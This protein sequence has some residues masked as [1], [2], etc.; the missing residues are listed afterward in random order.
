M[1][2]INGQC[3]ESQVARLLEKTPEQQMMNRVVEGTGISPWE[4]R[5]LVDEVRKVYLPGKQFQLR[6]GQLMYT[7][8]SASEG[9]GKPLKECR[10][11]TVVLT[12]MSTE[13]RPMHGEPGYGEGVAWQRRKKIIRMT[14]EARDQ[15]GLLSQEDLAQLL[16]SDVRT[17]RRD[18]DK[19][20]KTGIVVAT[21]GTIKDIG[22]G[23]THRELA[24]RHWLEG[25]EPVDVARAINH[26]VHA[27]ERYI[28][29]FIRTAYLRRRGFAPLQIALTIGRSGASV[30]IYLG[31]YER[32]RHG[33]Q[34]RSRFEHIDLVGSAHY[35]AEDEK[36]M[37]SSPKRSSRN[38]W[39]RQ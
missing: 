16:C 23:V 8:V 1:V 21:R 29:S 32:Y 18:I 4:A 2:K 20:R 31:I 36:K 24:I 30:G 38:A 11:E 37:P 19:L 12:L 17:M 10:M 35:E 28:Q 5:V 27:V 39:R 26:T 6:S 13:D 9:P 33:A 22:P 25:K 15:S 34:F 7:C 14:E 3:L